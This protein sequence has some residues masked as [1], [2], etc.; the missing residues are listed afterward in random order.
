MKDF[1][2]LIPVRDRGTDWRRAANLE[3]SLQWWR[4]RGINPVVVDDGLAGD[5]QFNRSRAYNRGAELSKA[6]ILCYIE[7]DLLIPVNQLYDAVCLA[8]QG[9]GLVVAFSKFLAMIERDTELVRAGF[10]PPAQACAQQMR[11]DNQSIGAANIVSRRSLEMTGGFDENF[12]GHA[13]DDDATEY[14]RRIS[15]FGSAGGGSSGHQAGAAAGARSLPQAHDARAAGADP[16]EWAKTHREFARAFESFP[17][18]AD[19][20]YPGWRA[21]LGV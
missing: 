3:A 6:D 17:A 20:L 21:T 19:T 16:I 4:A 15:L 12:S 10:I 9:P 5:A 18:D 8:S 7:A 2:V 14:A 11:G 13:Y 1:D